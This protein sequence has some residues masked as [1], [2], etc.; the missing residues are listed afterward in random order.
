MQLETI[1]CA[2]CGSEII[3]RGE[4]IRDDAGAF[5]DPE[6]YSP[7]TIALL[8]AENADLK[9]QLIE[10]RGQWTA[11]YFAKLVAN[12][13][14]PYDFHGDD[15]AWVAWLCKMY[16]PMTQEEFWHF[17][18]QQEEDEFNHCNWHYWHVAITRAFDLLH[19][20]DE[21]KRLAARADEIE[22]LFVAGDKHARIDE[23]TGGH[24]ECPY[25]DETIERHWWTRGYANMARILR[26]LKAEE[27]NRE[28]EA[29]I[30][31]QEAELAKWRQASPEI[32]TLRIAQEEAKKNKAAKLAEFTELYR[33]EGDKA[34]DPL[35]RVNLKVGAQSF[36][37]ADQL[38][39][40]GEAEWFERALIIALAN[41][42]DRYSPDARIEDLKQ[43]V[44]DRDGWIWQYNQNSKQIG[45]LLKPIR[46][47]RYT[48]EPA[49]SD[50]AEIRA[51]IVR[52]R[53][54][55]KTCQNLV[56]ALAR[57]RKAYKDVNDIGDSSHWNELEDA[58]ATLL[59]L[60]NSARAILSPI[61]KI[62]IKED[63][64]NAS[65]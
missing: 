56:D 24:T 4:M 36:T 48:G 10:L 17:C 18:Q 58:S 49:R 28:L 29:R 13:P 47:K 27:K 46:E 43:K 61:A 21:A 65:N 40:I 54:V 41:L 8:E 26:A 2:T 44:Q 19:E 16:Q 11:D 9:R 42:V 32:A 63:T 3:N 39:D 35:Y 31:A 6:C 45:E 34:Q 64:P 1:I 7:R 51:L 15:E 37:V 33:I 14:K 59:I 57:Q 25:A 23:D 50:V 55:E 38:E 30:R 22:A 5:C 53:N 60:E 20:R 52:L 62:E 12:N